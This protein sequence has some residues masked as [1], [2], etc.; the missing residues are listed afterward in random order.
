MQRHA[1]EELAYYRF[2]SLA[3]CDDLVHGVFTRRGGV[4]TG[5]WSS[6]NLSR[7]TG[8]HAIAVRENRARM[9]AALGTSAHQ[10]ITSWL[11]H[12]NV[13]RT[14]ERATL[15]EPNCDDE[16]AD[17]MITNVPGIT[18]TMRYADCV[19]ILFYDPVTH[20]IGLAHAGWHGIVRGIIP[21]T[22]A[23][24]ASEFGCRPSDIRACVGPSIGPGKFEVGEDVAAQIQHAVADSIIVRPPT[25]KL[26]AEPKPKVNLW[27]AVT[28]QIFESGLK[29]IECSNI[30]TASNLDEWF[31]HRAERGATGRFGIGIRLS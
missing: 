26:V 22:I 13:V 17:G 2:E 27:L 10:S 6:L 14:I 23:K 24:M 3:S 29:H 28:S 21:A 1:C 15:A 9:Y 31:S 4:S 20:S 18:L 25:S 7:S 11:V 8:D 12:G 30:C 16:H 5:V 19:P